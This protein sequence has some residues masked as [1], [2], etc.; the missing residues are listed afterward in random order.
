MD[1]LKYVSIDGVPYCAGSIR[2]KNTVAVVLTPKVPSLSRANVTVGCSDATTLDEHAAINAQ[3]N[4][5]SN[6]KSN[7][8]RVRD[9]IL[10]PL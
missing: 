9:F 5:K 6:G 1:R 2:D 7:I 3:N 4:G 8:K 10:S